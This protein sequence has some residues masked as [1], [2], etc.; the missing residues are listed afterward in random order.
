MNGNKNKSPVPRVYWDRSPKTKKK[1]GE[2]GRGPSLYLI[3]IKKSARRKTL[4]FLIKK[5]G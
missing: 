4:P 3:G 1:R 5:R 2:G